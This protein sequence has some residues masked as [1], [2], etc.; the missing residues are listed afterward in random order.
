MPRVRNGTLKFISRPTRFPVSGKIGQELCV[1][2]GENLFDTF[3]LYDH[4][5]M[6]LLSL[7]CGFVQYDAGGYAGV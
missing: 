5:L 3:Q 6:P 1:V 2:N 7:P 4:F